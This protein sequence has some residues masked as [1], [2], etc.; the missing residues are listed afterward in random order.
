MDKTEKKETAELTP[1]EEFDALKT[2]AA[3]LLK[4]AKTEKRDLTDEERADNEKR[5]SRMNELKR[6]NDDEQKLAELEAV[7]F[8]DAVNPEVRDD[9][10]TDPSRQAFSNKPAAQTRITVSE[11]RAAKDRYAKHVAAVEHYIRTGE[12]RREEF[13][14]TT[15]T[16]SGVLVPKDVTPPTFIRR[17]FN[18]I[19]LALAAYGLQPMLTQGTETVSVPLFDD[20]A[21]DGVITSE[22]STNETTSPGDPSAANGDAGNPG[23]QLGAKLF[24]SGI[25]WNSNTQLSAITYDLLGFLEPMLNKR[26]DHKQAVAWFAQIMSESN[27]G[28]TTSSPTG[29][30]Y[31][32]V[33]NFFYSLPYAYRSDGCFFGSDGFYQSLSDLKDS[34]GRPIYRTSM[35]DGEPNTLFG[36]PA[37]TTDALQSVAAGHI[38]AVFASAEALKV[39]IVENKRLVRYVNIPTHP[40]QVGLQQFVN[41]DFGFIPAG[42]CVLKQAAS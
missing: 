7:K 6:L 32:D 22:G 4:K 35:R 42:V 9:V 25:V 39:R 33:N 41:A 31:D 21:I 17:I 26:I 8:A 19:Y 13:A 29:V 12:I 1:R 27:V 34:L 10:V 40:D 11:D 28:A 38:T 15:S 14:I 37:F 36:K 5:F 30:T 3:E 2:E 16:G 20:S 18:P 24:D 23:I